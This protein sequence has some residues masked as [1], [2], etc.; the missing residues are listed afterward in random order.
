M[1]QSIT[2]ESLF[3][4]EQLIRAIKKGDYTK[5][6]SKTI[7]GKQPLQET[8]TLAKSVVGGPF[9]DSGTASRLMVGDIW[10]DRPV[11]ALLKLLGP[12]TVA[13]IAYMKPLGLKPT[14]AALR[15][16]GS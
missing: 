11:S 1:I 12:A 3:T 8:A 15:A 13:D 4:P 14:E 10:Q 6:K 5:R 2:K 9:P 16:P 7:K